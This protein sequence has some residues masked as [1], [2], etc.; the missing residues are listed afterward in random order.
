MF[1]KKRIISLT[2]AIYIYKR[3]YNKYT[4][5]SLAEKFQHRGKTSMCRGQ[6]G[7]VSRCSDHD[8]LLCCGQTVAPRYRVLKAFQCIC[9]DRFSRYNDYVAIME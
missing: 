2:I 8:H 4:S 3:Y 7:G 6:V 1:K 9:F 5:T